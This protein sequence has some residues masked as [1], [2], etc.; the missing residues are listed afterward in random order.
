MS[1]NTNYNPN[2]SDPS[3]DNEPDRWNPDNL[4]SVQ[5]VNDLFVDEDEDLFADDNN[6]ENTPY[7]LKTIT[8]LKTI[9]V[10]NKQIFFY[11]LSS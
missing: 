5:F 6:Q 7:P 11:H 4:E 3:I 10:I 8:F 9:T 1:A 2:D